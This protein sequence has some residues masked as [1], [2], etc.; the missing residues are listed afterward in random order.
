MGRE[1]YE[2]MEFKIKVG[3][4][5]VSDRCFRRERR[6]ESGAIIKELVEDKLKGQVNFYTIVPDEWEPI[7]SAILQAVDEYSVD[8][9]LTTGGTG[10]SRRDITPEVTATLIEKEVPGISEI[11]RVEGFKNNP[12]SVLSRGI[13]GLK[14]GTLIINLPGSPNGVKECFLT[15][16]PV[17][18]HAIK[19]IKGLPDFH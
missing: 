16:L 8:L 11:M 7:K 14:K 6:D 13:C 15:I 9:L 12:F 19:T 5:T 18:V 2:A 17:L 4:I 1:F 10:L 3:V